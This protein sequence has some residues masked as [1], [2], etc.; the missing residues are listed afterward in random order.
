[1]DP[2]DEI[3]RRL[4]K[5][6]E[7]FNHKTQQAKE[8]KEKQIALIHFVLDTVKEIHPSV[9][10]QMFGS[11]DN[12]GVSDYPTVTVYAYHRPSGVQLTKWL[13]TADG[14]TPLPRYTKES[15]IN[16]ILKALDRI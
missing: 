4:D 3:H 16:G 13:I 15:I 12:E 8:L 7:V 10:A 9:E 1:M 5:I 6:Q 14:E 2:I 11:Y